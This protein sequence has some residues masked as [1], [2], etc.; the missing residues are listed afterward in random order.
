VKVSK[1]ALLDSRYYIFDL[2]PL[3]EGNRSVTE[4]VEHQVEEFRTV[5]STPTSFTVSG[6]EFPLPVA[7]SAGL[8]RIVQEG[9]ANIYKHAQA[10]EVKVRL[11]FKPGEVQL[12]IKDNGRGFEALPLSSPRAGERQRGAGGYGLGNMA[13]RARELGGRLAVDSV[14]GQGTSLNL[15][16]PIPSASSTP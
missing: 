4:M 5:T 9:L 2:K 1:Q 16:L 15:T 7:S 14:P 13:T 10:S 11:A 8:Y 6:Q 12:E 3:L